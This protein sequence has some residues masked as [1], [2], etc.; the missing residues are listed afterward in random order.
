MAFAVATLSIGAILS[1]TPILPVIAPAMADDA[2]ERET[3]IE[4]AQDQVKEIAGS[5]KGLARGS[6]SGPIVDAA[7]ETVALKKIL[8]S[9]RK[10]AGED[11]TAQ[12]ITEEWRKPI[13]QFLR[14]TPVLQRMKEN[15]YANDD[16][17][18]RC[19]DNEK[20]LA[21]KIKDFVN[22]EDPDGLVE[23]PQI[24]RAMKASTANALVA[25]RKAEDIVSEGK[26]DAGRFRVG[27]DWDPVA[28]AVGR[29]ADAMADHAEDALKAAERACADLYKGPKHPDILAARKQIASVTGAKVKLLQVAVDEWEE[30][31]KKYFDL[32]CAGMKEIAKAYCGADW[33]KTEKSFGGNHKNAEKTADSISRALRSAHMDLM[34]ELKGIKK[35]HKGLLEDNETE[36]EAREIFKESKDELK[37]LTRLEKRGAQLGGKHP[38]VG[39]YVDFGRKMHKRMEGSFSCDV[40]DQPYPGL[41]GR[42]DCIRA[43]KCQV[44]EFKPNSP[45][46]VKVGKGQVRGYIG[47]VESYYADFIGSDKA[48]KSSLG[49]KKIMEAFAKRGCIKG[50]DI[51]LKGIVKTYDRCDQSQYQCAN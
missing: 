22:A 13:A 23:L 2:R 37:V 38:I 45:N 31:A 6:D 3:L 20:D 27:G 12:A 41:K 25:A 48:P 11:E 49:G 51:S 15:Q 36:D 5:L 17:A 47:K 43:Q 50:D 29:E 14:I 44:I 16:L 10:V 9:L 8:K 1:F 28:D 46:G 30:K 21:G 33:E 4:D 26:R 24:G 39:Y 19:E 42:P 18:D 32:D 7:K 40:R 35:D 34:N